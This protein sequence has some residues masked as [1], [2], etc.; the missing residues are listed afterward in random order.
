V[1]TWK[2]EFDRRCRRLL[3]IT[4]DDRGP[5]E[6]EMESVYYSTMTGGETSVVVRCGERSREFMDM[7]DVIRALDEIPDGA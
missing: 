6:I 4:D 5:V 3:G 2:D 1:S 7:G